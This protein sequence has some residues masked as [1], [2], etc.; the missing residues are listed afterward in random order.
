M[1]I[2]IK[3]KTENTI[4]ESVTESLIQLIREYK[5]NT[6]TTKLNVH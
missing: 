1:K 3:I 2:K 5:A 6:M 4:F